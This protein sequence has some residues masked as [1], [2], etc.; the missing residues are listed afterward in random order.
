MKTKLS[1]LSIVY[2]NISVSKQRLTMYL[3]AV[4][5]PWSTLLKAFFFKPPWD[6]MLRTNEKKQILD[7]RD[8]FET[9]YMLNHPSKGPEVQWTPQNSDITIK[10][11]TIRS[12]DGSE[13]F[14]QNIYDWLPVAD[15]VVVDIGASIGDSPLYFA[16]KGAKHVFAFEADVNIFVI[17]LYNITRNF[18]QD[19]ITLENRRILG[20]NYTKGKIMKIEQNYS[21]EITQ[22]GPNE[23]AVMPKT[24]EE[25]IKEREIEDAVLKIDCE[26]C[27]YGVILSA[28]ADTIRHFSHI[29][30][31]YHFGMRKLKKRLIGIG[32]EVKVSRNR[33]SKSPDTRILM[34]AGDLYAT[35]IGK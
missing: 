10:L 34:K 13:V 22:S 23:D 28:S 4:K 31:E 9:V 12:N 6:I 8:L 5:N 15:K 35:R 19:L 2:G 1:P 3:K 33:Y 21:E 20:D 29:Q 16:S 25:I 14:E 30:M 27:E 7:K 17:A 24:L 32:Y 11:K 18:C 26:G